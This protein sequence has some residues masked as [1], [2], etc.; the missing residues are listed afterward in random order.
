[1][2]CSRELNKSRI[3]GNNISFP[4][5]KIPESKIR[6]G[7]GNPKTQ[8]MPA[9]AVLGQEQ[10]QQQRSCCPYLAGDD[11]RRVSRF[12]LV[13]RLAQVALWI[14]SCSLL[15]LTAQNR[16]NHWDIDDTD[17]DKCRRDRHVKTMVVWLFA[18]LSAAT[19]LFSILLETFM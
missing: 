18:V 14:P 4:E 16:D 1:M 8:T 9:L 13:G 10:Q 19:I 6:I 12:V 17:N 7:W 3:F 15:W 11:L 5:S 2:R